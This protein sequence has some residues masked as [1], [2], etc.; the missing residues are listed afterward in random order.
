MSYASTIIGLITVRYNW[1]NK[2]CITLYSRFGLGFQL[3]EKEEIYYNGDG[4]S[5]CTGPGG[6]FACQITPVGIE[7]GKGLVR[8]YSELGLGQTG[9]LEMGLRLKL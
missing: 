8:F 4:Q 2:S 3:A 7:L 9:C 5:M 1:L 6:Y